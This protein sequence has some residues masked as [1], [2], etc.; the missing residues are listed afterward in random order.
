MLAGPG[1]LPLPT[2]PA[3][4]HGGKLRVGTFGTPASPSGSPAIP[5]GGI[6]STFSK[7]GTQPIKEPAILARL[8]FHGVDT[9]T[10]GIA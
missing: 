6:E 2:P 4:V 3:Y 8:L 9:I 1:R 5:G 7:T 10:R